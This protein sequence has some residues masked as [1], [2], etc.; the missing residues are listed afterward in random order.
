MSYPRKSKATTPGISGHGALR[1]VLEAAFERAIS[2]AALSAQVDPYRLDT[3][4]GHRDG[5]W[6]AKQLARARP[7]SPHPW[8]ELHYAVVAAGNIR[9]PDGTEATHA[10]V[11]HKSYGGEE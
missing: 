7:R 9:R 6:A 8:R 4:S 10:L 3:A 1:S 5:A 2:A 11:V